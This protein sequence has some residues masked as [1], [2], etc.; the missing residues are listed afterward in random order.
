[1][2]RYCSFWDGHYYY[3]GELQ[4]GLGNVIMFESSTSD[5]YI[6]FEYSFICLSTSLE[7]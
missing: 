1:M 5:S 7:K 3:N 6:C 2:K 4:P